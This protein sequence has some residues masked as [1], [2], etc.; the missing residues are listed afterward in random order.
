MRDRTLFLCRAANIAALY[1]ALTL[2]SHLFG[3]ANGV[4]QL[5]LSEALCVLPVFTA[6]AI[7]GL[8]V[9][10]LLA[11]LLCG[12]TLIDILLGAAATL[13]GALGSRLL[14]KFPAAVPIPTVL[15]NALCVPLILRFAG[16]SGA[17]YWYLAAV[18]GAGEF[19]SAYVLGLMLRGA[20]RSRE[21]IFFK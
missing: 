15:A 18:I 11:N 13:L 6:A 7:P 5:R 20:L 9:G 14:R 2:L 3:L 4:F 17:S 21:D 8:F 19:L 1:T 12:G 16:A 10:C